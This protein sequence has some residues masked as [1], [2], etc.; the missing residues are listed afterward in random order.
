MRHPAWVFDTRGVVDAAAVQAAGLQ[1]WQ[2][3]RG[4]Y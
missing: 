4:M 3:G 1:L 2:L